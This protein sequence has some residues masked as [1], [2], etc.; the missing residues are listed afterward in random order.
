MRHRGLRVDVDHPLGQALG[1]IRS[2]LRF[3]KT[4]IDTYAPPP[5]FGEHTDEVL[6][7]VLGIDESQ[8]ERLRQFGVI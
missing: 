8:R 3:S 6:G 7:T 4:P 1:L 2:P 5:M